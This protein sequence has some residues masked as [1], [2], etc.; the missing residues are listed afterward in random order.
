M[1]NNNISKFEEYIE[2]NYFSGHEPDENDIP[3]IKE[4]WDAC[5]KQVLKELE[6]FEGEYV[7]D[8]ID[9]IKKL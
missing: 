7:C 1:K 9:R 2:S 3:K 8:V 4:G 6:G 5:K